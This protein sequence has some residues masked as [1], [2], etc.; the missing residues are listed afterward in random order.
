MTAVKRFILPPP[1]LEWRHDTQHND[2]N[3]NDTQREEPICDAQHK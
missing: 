3:H 2:I 1:Y